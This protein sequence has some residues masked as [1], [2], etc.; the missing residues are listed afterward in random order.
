M[1][2]SL[3]TQENQISKP[4]Q[5]GLFELRVGNERY[6]SN[7]IEF[8]DIIPKY[9]YGRTDRK[10]IID[11]KTKSI[12]YVLPSLAR[13]IKYNKEGVKY[14]VNINPAII[15][16]KDSKTGYN[17]STYYYPTT[18]E[19]L[20]EEVLRKL[21]AIGKGGFLNDDVSVYFSL[22]EIQ[23]DLQDN[24][25]T[26]SITEIKESLDIMSKTHI[27]IVS[28]KGDTEYK[29]NIIITL[30]LA[31]K[32]RG[33]TK[34]FCSL[35]PLVSKSIKQLSFRKY[36]YS[37][38]MKYKSPIARYLHKRISHYY[39]QT[40]KEHPYIIK[41]ST[42]FNDSGNTMEANMTKNKQRVES[43]LNELLE[44]KTIVNFKLEPIK[45]K[46]VKMKTLDYKI[47]IV[48]SDSFISDI[49]SANAKEKYNQVQGKIKAQI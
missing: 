29:G 38:C 4:F 16:K 18:R 14:N 22:R 12:M 41:L 35:N 43:A 25:H 3:E 8:W 42:L 47:Y 39:K 1:N 15:V 11:E 28:D 27:E 19:E 13:E 10:K 20:V 2:T 23:Q 48:P 9:F 26:Y 7:T 33:G 32:G 49:I 36:D 21:I 40:D 30:A 6:Y 44:E 31:T 17:I 46:E 37:K 24:G 34:C 45:T 5:L